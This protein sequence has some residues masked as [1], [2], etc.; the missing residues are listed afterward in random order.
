ACLRSTVPR[1]RFGCPLDH[2]TIWRSA[3]L[4]A[5]TAAERREANGPGG[6]DGVAFQPEQQTAADRVGFDETHGHRVAECELPVGAAPHEPMPPG[7]V[8]IIIRRQT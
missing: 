5:A 1:T 7:V 8:V 4:A 2:R 6:R 3:S